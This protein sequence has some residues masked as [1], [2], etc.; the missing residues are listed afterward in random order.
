[1]SADAPADDLPAEDRIE[2]EGERLDRNW[3]EILQELR[4]TQAGTQILTGFL[5][6]I[7][8]QS[9]FTELDR[10]ELNVY[11]TLVILAALSTVLGLA[12]VSLHRLLFRRG[13][14]RRV[15]RVANTILRICLIVGSI[16]VT[17]V[18]FFIF[19]VVLGL[20]AGLVA[21]VIVGAAVVVTWLVIPVM[22]R[23][24]SPDPD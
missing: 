18:A 13:L 2:S 20:A 6:A 9:R 21:G 12:P 23:R 10:A 17:G 7:A 8:F 3:N 11:L 24:G 16:L 22:L 5:L 1:M 4:V 14:K 15:V 19:D